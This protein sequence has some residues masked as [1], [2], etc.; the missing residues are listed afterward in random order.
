MKH[1]KKIW[2]L[3]WNKAEKKKHGKLFSVHWNN[4]KAFSIINILLA[5]LYYYKKPPKFKTIL[6]WRSSRKMNRNKKLLII[7]YLW[8]KPSN[9]SNSHKKAFHAFSFQLRS[10]TNSK[11]FVH[12]SLCEIN[13]IKFQTRSLVSKSIYFNRD[14]LC[15]IYFDVIIRQWL[16][17][18]SG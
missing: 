16:K 15:F 17:K 8:E 1:E 5:N 13:C 12:V 9:F 3:L 10:K 4:S 14:S 6:I 7:N 11:F 18:S 2:N